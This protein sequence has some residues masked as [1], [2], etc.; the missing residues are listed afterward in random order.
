[1]LNGAPEG[2]PRGMIADALRMSGV[3]RSAERMRLF[4][5][6]MQMCGVRTRFNEGDPRTVRRRVMAL[7]MALMMLAVHK[8]RPV[9]AR[10]VGPRHAARIT[11]HSPPCRRR[12][13]R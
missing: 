6:V 2:G 10:T 3:P 13:G 4:F 8:M 1:M 12:I 7:A 9:G 5:D 11:H